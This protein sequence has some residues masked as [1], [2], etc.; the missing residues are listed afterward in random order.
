MFRDQIRRV[1]VDQIVPECF[2]GC[3]YGAC[4]YYKDFYNPPQHKTP[5]PFSKDVKGNKIELQHYIERD[6]YNNTQWNVKWQGKTLKTKGKVFTDESEVAVF[7]KLQGSD[8]S[9]IAETVSNKLPPS[10]QKHDQK[11]SIS[12]DDFS[13]YIDGETF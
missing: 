3:R 6:D 8:N 1:A 5:E 10:S 12:Q 2:R 9:R 11:H 4:G 13:T 7:K